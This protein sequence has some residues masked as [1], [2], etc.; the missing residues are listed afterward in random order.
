M[1]RQERDDEAGGEKLNRR[2]SLEV[3]LSWVV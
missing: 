3:E 2:C 1:T